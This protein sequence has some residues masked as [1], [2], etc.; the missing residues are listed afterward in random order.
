MVSF[1]LHQQLSHLLLFDFDGTLFKTL[2]P[3]PRGRDVNT[4]S[5]WAVYQ[6]F[7]ELGI[8]I[9]DAQGGL[10][11]RA[12]SELV[13]DIL[14][15]KPNKGPEVS[16]QNRDELV[17][18]AAIFFDE[19]IS[20]LET[21]IPSKRGINL[22]WEDGTPQS[23]ISE[24]F[25]KTKLHA[26]MSEIS[27]QWPLP[28]KGFTEFWQTLQEL[29]QRGLQLDIGIVSSGHEL[30]IKKV[31]ELWNLQFDI[32][33]TEDEVRES[34][35]PTEGRT[36]PGPLPILLALKEWQN[37]PGRVHGENAVYAPMLE[38]RVMYVG[39]DVKKD[40]GMAEKVGLVG[41]HFQDN[42]QPLT[43]ETDGWKMQFHD[44]RDFGIF[45]KQNENNLREGAVFHKMCREYQHSSVI[46]NIQLGRGIER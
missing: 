34:P 40:V 23:V 4:A 17:R 15:G 29:K 43:I 46:E 44:W 42:D 26:L 8:K 6:I 37:F 7:G 11:N 3:S 38:G 13:K 22:S 45:L 39:D 32:V 28:C 5:R 18:H 10:E 9:Y 24:L 20:D 35:L 1:P 33:I 30:F 41:G 25:V 36:K 31:L 12:P 21:D 2:L 14:Y 19:N 27:P 16:P